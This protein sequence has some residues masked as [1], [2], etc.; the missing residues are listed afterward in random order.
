[1]PQST[2]VDGVNVLVSRNHGACLSKFGISRR[3]GHGTIEFLD[4]GVSNPWTT[5]RKVLMGLV[6]RVVI[7]KQGPITREQKSESIGR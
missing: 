2:A 6:R 5:N 4:L 7:S 3:F 1:M